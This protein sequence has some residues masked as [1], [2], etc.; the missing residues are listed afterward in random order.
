MPVYLD[1]GDNF[2]LVAGRLFL[3]L[4]PVPFA[5][6]GSLDI[7]VQVLVTQH[8]RRGRSNL[9]LIVIAEKVIAF[10]VVVN[11]TLRVRHREV[12]SRAARGRLGKL[13]ATTECVRELFCG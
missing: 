13:M 5:L 11:W 8:L 12:G 1:A 6:V 4:A 3:A 2:V 10:V 9:V 7:R